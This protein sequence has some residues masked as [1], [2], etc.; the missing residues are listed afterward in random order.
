MGILQFTVESS[1]LPTFHCTSFSLIAKNNIILVT[2]PNFHNITLASDESMILSTKIMLAS[3][4]ATSELGSTLPL[5][6]YSST[7]STIASAAAGL[8]LSCSK[9]GQTKRGSWYSKEAWKNGRMQVDSITVAEIKSFL[10]IYMVYNK[11]LSESK[12]RKPDY[13]QQALEKEMDGE[14]GLWKYTLFVASLGTG[15]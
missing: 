12:V 4:V 8:S 11:T 15:K 2:S 3:A 14:L 10:Y 6:N 13:V 1:L 5:Q 7:I 9:D